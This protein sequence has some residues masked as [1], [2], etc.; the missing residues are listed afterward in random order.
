MKQAKWERR[1]L[2]TMGRFVSYHLCCSYG[3]TEATRDQMLVRILP[4]YLNLEV[5]KGFTFEMEPVFPYNDRA[6]IDDRDTGL[7]VLAYTERFVRVCVVLMLVLYDEYLL[8]YLPQDVISFVRHLGMAIETALESR[9]K[10]REMLELFIV[11]ESTRWNL[12]PSP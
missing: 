5:R 3:V 9:A 8:W 10:A 6:F 11:I 1:T 7:W 12:L 4:A 2:S